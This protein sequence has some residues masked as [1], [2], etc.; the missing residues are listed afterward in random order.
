MVYGLKPKVWGRFGPDPLAEDQVNTSGGKD[1]RARH[2]WSIHKEIQEIKNA[3]PKRMKS[4]L[5]GWFHHGKQRLYFTSNAVIWLPSLLAIHMLDI[6]LICLGPQIILS[7]TPRHY[8]RVY[9]SGINDSL[10]FGNGNRRKT[11]QS[12]AADQTFIQEL[13]PIFL[14][15]NSANGNLQIILTQVLKH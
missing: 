7:F 13:F 9:T 11:S 15:A 1:P 2:T 5:S 3:S 10:C 4:H 14:A 12:H 8:L 6:Y